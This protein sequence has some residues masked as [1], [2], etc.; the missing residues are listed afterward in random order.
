[1]KLVLLRHAA[2]SAQSLG[3]SPLNEIGRRQ[4]EDLTHFISPHGPLPT[5]TLLLTS[6]KRRARETLTPLSGSLSLQLQID[7]R[8]DER[9]T[10]ESMK[11]FDSR[12]RELLEE[13]TPLEERKGC[14]YLCSHLDWLESAIVHL[15]SD[16]S[17]LEA[18]LPWPVASFRVFR[19][20]DGLWIFKGS[21]AV[22]MR[23]SGE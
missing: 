3:D 16:I 13:I 14:V 10:S 5:P 18:S 7:E 23:S 15:P 12:V 22:P 17:E 20:Q 1:M 11:D 19:W 21:S 6:P 8:L 4:A 2:R 9:H